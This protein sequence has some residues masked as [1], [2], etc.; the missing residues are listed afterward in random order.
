MPSVVMKGAAQ[1]LVIARS[2]AMWQSMVYGI[3]LLR[4]SR[5]DREGP[6]NDNSL[7]R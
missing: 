7:C 6:R 3:G 5:N 4:C 2:A 1:I